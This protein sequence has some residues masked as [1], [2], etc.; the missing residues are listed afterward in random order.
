M[1]GIPDKCPVPWSEFQDAISRTAETSFIAPEQKRY[2]ECLV[3]P[4]RGN[5]VLI[6]AVLVV[7]SNSVISVMKHTVCNDW[8]HAH[9]GWQVERVMKS[10]P[11]GSELT[12]VTESSDVALGFKRCVEQYAR[13]CN[14]PEDYTSI[15]QW[16]HMLKTI[17]E[18]GIRFWAKV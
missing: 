3:A 8:P 16:F 1:F 17:G 18:R 10:I 9:G 14:Q 4:G 12:V 5:D 7:W 15:L 6:G 13:G 11:P 2:E